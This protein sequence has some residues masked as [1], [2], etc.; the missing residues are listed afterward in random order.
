MRYFLEIAYK[1]NNYHGW[2]V[3][4]N[5]VTVQEILDDC[6]ATLLKITPPSLGCGRTDAGVHATS[7]FVQFDIETAITDTTKTLYQLNSMLPHDI[8]C[9]S[10][11]Q[12]KPDT[13]A[14]FDATHRRYEYRIH[15]LK[16]PFLH[17]Q[18]VHAKQA[19]DVELMNQGAQMLLDYTDFASF[20][21]AGSDNYTTNCKVSKAQWVWKNDNQLIFTIQADRFLRNMVRAIVGTLFLLGKHQITLQEFKNIIEAKNRSNAGSSAK[22]HGLFLVE[23]GYDFEKIAVSK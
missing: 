15:F 21:K 6:L 8:A 11:I 14:R 10:L 23:V 19:L 9:K 20:C 13:N 22:G 3:Q 17:Q 5:A 4:K 2:Q 7:F 18:S 1:G 12:V 16:D